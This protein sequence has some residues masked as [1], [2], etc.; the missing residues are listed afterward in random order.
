M[1]DFI[2]LP[3]RRANNNHSRSEPMGSGISMLIGTAD[4]HRQVD[5]L[6]SAIHDGCGLRQVRSQV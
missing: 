6:S 4:V 5:L 1:M 3:R 2:F